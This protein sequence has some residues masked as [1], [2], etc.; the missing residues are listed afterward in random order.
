MSIIINR[1]GMSNETEELKFIHLADTDGILLAVPCM[2]Y[3]RDAK[4]LAIASKLSFNT[5]ITFPV[6]TASPAT[7]DEKIQADLDKSLSNGDKVIFNTKTGDIVVKNGDMQIK[8]FEVYP[9]K[10]QKEYS[11]IG[12]QFCL[13]VCYCDPKDDKDKIGYFYPQAYEKVN[14]LYAL[15]TI[16]RRKLMFSEGDV[17]EKFGLSLAVNLVKTYFHEKDTLE[18]EEGLSKNFKPTVLDDLGNLAMYDEL[19]KLGDTLKDMIEEEKN[20]AGKKDEEKE[21]ETKTVIDEYLDDVSNM[22]GP[23]RNRFANDFLDDLDAKDAVIDKVEIIPVRDVKEVVK[24]IYNPLTNPIRDEIINPIQMELQ[25]D[26]YKINEL[27]RHRPS[28][29]IAG[30]TFERK[31]KRKIGLY[32]ILN[33]HL[34]INEFPVDVNIDVV[35]Q[36]EVI[37][38]MEWTA[39]KNL[40]LYITHLEDLHPET[41][42]I[43]DGFEITFMEAHQ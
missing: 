16:K 35:L 36:P 5:T 30:E 21:E 3:T 22:Y 25:G 23:K 8:M 4:E 11:G 17:C 40:T 18:I 33:K 9:F 6:G 27:L 2:F 26:V 41:L 24:S 14:L 34:L 1:A 37:K 12:Y 15:S 10:F 39:T 28:L 20:K 43:F 13:G 38:R 31:E 19:I 29:L 7:I 42:E 32:D